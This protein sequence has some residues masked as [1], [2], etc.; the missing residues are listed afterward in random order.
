MTMHRISVMLLTLLTAAQAKAQDLFETTVTDVAA[1]KSGHALVVC[2]GDADIENGVCRTR[3]VPV[4]TLGTF[5]AFAADDNGDATVRNVRVQQ[6]PVDTKRECLTLTDMLRANQGRMARLIE[7][8]EHGPPAEVSGRILGILARQETVESPVAHGSQPG[9]DRWGRYRTGPQATATHITETTRDATFAM[10]ASDQGTR[11]IRL[12]NLRGLTILGAPAEDR[13]T[14]QEEVREMT[15]TLARDAGPP[16]K[17]AKIGMVYLQKGVRWIPAYRIQL[18]DDGKARIR[19]FATVINELRDLEDVTLNLVVGVPSFIMDDT[20]SP[21]ALREHPLEL[22]RFFRPADGTTRAAAATAFSNNIMT[23]VLATQAETGHAAPAPATGLALPGEG[24]QEDLFVYRHP[25]FSLPKG[26]V[27]QLELLDTTVEYNDLYVVDLPAIPPE[28][29]WRH[30]SQQ[31]HHQLREAAASARAVHH[32][33]LENSGTTPWTTGPATIFSGNTVLGQGLM[34]YTS[35][36]NTAELPVTVATDIHT[37]IVD[38]ETN[39]KSGIAINTVNYTRVDLI[40]AVKLTNYKQRPVQVRVTRHVVGA[41]DAVEQ[42]GR[43]RT[44]QS[45]GA[46]RLDSRDWPWFDWSWPWW[47]YRVNPICTAEWNTTLAPGEATEFQLK[48]HYFYH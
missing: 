25:G 47:M 31:F 36:G 40:G 8:R 29:T 12:D 1:F 34:R 18:L 24:R 26:A 6:R 19:L 27:A 38:A 44:A 15:I 20:P 13:V 45:L 23:Q 16:P 21:L 43:I 3:D 10:I 30:V 28:V 2:T 42:D 14:R 5:W 22:G 11:M 48:W 39:R 17:R 7:D 41:I 32:L 4:P 35:V 33:S 9:Y 37:A 46:A